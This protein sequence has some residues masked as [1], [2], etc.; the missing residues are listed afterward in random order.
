MTNTAISS[1]IKLNPSTAR[2]L[3]PWRIDGDIFNL[4][5]LRAP[6][7]QIGTLGLSSGQAI[8]A[9]AKNIN[10]AIFPREKIEVVAA[11][12]IYRNLL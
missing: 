9:V 6:V 12:G 8:G 7:T 11:P 10:L 3:R 4:A 1:S 5:L 2:G